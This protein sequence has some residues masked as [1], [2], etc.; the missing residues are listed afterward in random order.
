[1][2]AHRLQAILP[3]IPLSS[4]LPKSMCRNSTREQVAERD[5]AIELMKEKTKAYI[6]K[7]TNDHA[8]ELA[9]ARASNSQTSPS[10]PQVL[11]EQLRCL[12]SSGSITPAILGI[13]IIVNPTLDSILNIV[14]NPTKPNPGTD[15]TL[16]VENLRRSRNVNSRLSRCNLQP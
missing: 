5:R 1:M 3:Y 7:L 13:I 6:Q 10:V 2:E 16:V 15:R 4:S 9:L 8:E 12:G 11:Y 14:I